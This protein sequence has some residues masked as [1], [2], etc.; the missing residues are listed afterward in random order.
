MTKKTSTKYLGGI[1]LVIDF[2]VDRILGK[3]HSI[4]GSFL[5][6]NS[7]ILDC[8]YKHTAFAIFIV[9]SLTAYSGFQEK[10]I[11]CISGF[12]GKEPSTDIYSYCLSYPYVRKD[13]PR[14]Y[15]LFYKWTPWTL[16]C[17]GFMF[18]LPKYVVKATS[19]QHVSR[20][21]DLV[22]SQ[23]IASDKTVV[24]LRNN[25]N[26]LGGL[27]YKNL[28]S[29]IFAIG[30][31]AAVFFFSDFCLQGR[32][33]SYVPRALPFH[34]NITHFS[35]EISTTFPPFALCNASR[36]LFF[37]RTDIFK[38]QLLLMEYYEK[39][40]AVL[41]LWIVFLTI[42]TTLYVCFLASFHLPIVKLCI[43]NEITA[44]GNIFF[45]Y[46]LKGYSSR[47]QYAEILQRLGRGE[48]NKDG[49]SQCEIRNG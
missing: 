9:Y 13:G 3:K 42:V 39:I 37:D 34:R 2:L 38:C 31:N 35:D 4:S 20:F 21:L 18:Y 17:I 23:Q 25:W 45:L 7:L 36:E 10:S 41:W 27:F 29:H 11:A 48:K 14:T 46:K 30:I 49:L 26:F 16:L 5:T 24:F 28:F 40:F 19:C 8:L 15:L 22:A 33:S 44:V 12:D 47:K 43:F 1:T 6:S 32:F